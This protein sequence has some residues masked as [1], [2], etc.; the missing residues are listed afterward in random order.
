MDLGA[1]L[2]TALLLH[3]HGGSSEP[4]DLKHPAAADALIEVENHA[5]STSIQGWEREE[6]AVTGDVPRGAE[7]V[8]LEGDTHR[9]RIAVRRGRGESDLNIHVPKGSHVEVTGESSDVKI[10]GVQGGV[11]VQVVTGDVVIS[12]TSQEV[13]V[14][15]VQGDVTI[16]APA[17]KTHA[18]SVGGTVT[19]RGVSGEVQASA[20]S[21]D[22]VVEGKVFDA[23]H[24]GTVSGEL[25]FKG[26]LTPRGHLDGQSVSGDVT[27]HFPASIAA[28][29][30]ASSFSGDIETDFGATA[31]QSHRHMPSKDLSF[32]TGGGGAKVTVHTLSGTIAIRKLGSK[33]ED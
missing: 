11:R 29:F 14:N 10:S 27:L 32:S 16:D 19:V 17:R 30:Q 7:G 23:V 21:G 3:E 6:V 8:A 2:L 18:E 22:V 33:G 5:G 26:S 25:R 13:D 12:G 15:T 1:V 24:L 4:L 20:V 28:D 9:V 31:V